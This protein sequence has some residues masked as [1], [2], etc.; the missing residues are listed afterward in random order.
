MVARIWKPFQ[1][2]LPVTPITD[3][4]IKENDLIVATQGRAFYVIDD[5]AVLQQQIKLLHK[6][7]YIFLILL[8]PIEWM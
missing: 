1:Q 3:L 6:K 2:N 5:L 8:Q 7:I 4:T